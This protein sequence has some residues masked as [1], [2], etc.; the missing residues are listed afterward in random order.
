MHGR[1]E[2]SSSQG[3]NQRQGRWDRM[4]LEG[5]YYTFGGWGGTGMSEGRRWGVSLERILLLTHMGLY[6]QVHWARGP[7]EDPG[8]QRS[9]IRD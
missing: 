6:V 3:G 8:D 1:F 9:K 4:G 7:L 5:R 2:L